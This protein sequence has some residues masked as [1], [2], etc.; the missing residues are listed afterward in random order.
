MGKFPI[1]F[2]L[3]PLAAL[4][5]AFFGALH[6]Q[7]SYSVGPSYFTHF[8]FQQFNIAEAM[9][10]RFGAALVG[11]YASWWMGPLIALPAF[12]FGLFTVPT[13]RTYLA[14]GLGAIFLV[15]LLTTFG[16]LVGLVGGLVADNTGLL[17]PFLTL[18][19]GPTRS[20]FLRAGF[21]H[22][23]SYIA[24]AIGALAA[25]FPMRR[26]RQIDLHTARQEAAPHAT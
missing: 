20:D 12:L 10:P 25:F 9:P 8:K 7:L 2:L 23:A 13:A 17:D 16:A 14:A 22:D 26:A 21:M 4:A 5:A 6:N 19:D 18:R 11:V 24:G 15:I 1:F 3:L